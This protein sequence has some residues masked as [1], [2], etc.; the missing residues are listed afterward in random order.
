VNFAISSRSFIDVGALA[1]DDDAGP[2]R[3][4]GHAGAVGIALDD[5]LR[6]CRVLQT[7]L[8]EIPDADVLVQQI[9]KLLLVGKPPR[10]PIFLDANAKADRIYFLS[11]A[12]APFERT[13]K[14]AIFQPASYPSIQS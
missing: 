13:A 2:G 9:P 7:L 6:D 12:R 14:R 4:D 3:V 10:A 1:A 5:N 8:D 11:Q